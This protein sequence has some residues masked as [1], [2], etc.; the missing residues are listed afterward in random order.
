MRFR[1]LGSGSRGNA[2][3]IDSGKTRVLVDNGFTLKE[4]EQRSASIG[5]SLE[6][7]DAIL[8]THEHGDHIKGVGPLARRYNLPVYATHGTLRTGKCGKLAECH[9]IKLHGEKFDIGDMHIKPV[10]VPHDANEP[11]QFVFS[12]NK[13]RLGVLT[14]LGHITPVITEEFRKLSVRHEA[15][16]LVQLPTQQAGRLRE[17]CRGVLRGRRRSR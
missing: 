9:T 10:P 17:A 2:T 16:P 8:V 13:K 5:F 1:V 14:D 7:L 15:D 12:N 3:I 11:C 6:S 4:V